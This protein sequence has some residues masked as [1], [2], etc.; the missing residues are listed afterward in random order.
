[1]RVVVGM[2]GGV[3]SAVSAL[4]LKRAGYDVLGVSLIQQINAPAVENCLPDTTV[5]LR[6]DHATALRRRG[7]A[8]VLDRIESETAS[9][10]ARVEAAYDQLI[11]QDPE[12]F[13]IV[14]AREAP[15]T[16]TEKILSAL[17]PR[18]EAAGVV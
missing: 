17:I 3:D 5:F 2:S 13:I 15:E 4:L 1:M 14:D 6:L 8:S 12:R 7:K 11:A 9:F 10:H 16:I 18:M